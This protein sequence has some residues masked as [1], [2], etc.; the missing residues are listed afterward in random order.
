NLGFLSWPVPAIVH[1][2]LLGVEVFFF[3]SGFS[4][5]YPYARTLI[6]G[7]QLQTL[8]HFIERR[9]RKILPSYVVVVIVVALL[10]PAQIPFGESLWSHILVHL[11]FLHAFFPNAFVS[12][13][14]PL[15]SLAVEVEFYVIFPLLAWLAMRNLALALAL[16][17]AI[18]WGYR[19]WLA[20]T[21]LDG[22]FFFAYQMP[23]FLDLFAAGM[24]ASYL[25][26]A[27]QN[28]RL[29]WLAVER[30]ATT[31]ALVA[32]VLLDGLFGAMLQR[33]GGAGVW[34]WQND[35]RVALA[36]LLLCFTV[37]TAFSHPFLRIAVANRVTLWLAL[38]SYNLY[39]W[40][41]PII[42][43]IV[44]LWVYIQQ[45]AHPHAFLLIVALC[46]VL[47]VAQLTTRF[48][49]RPILEGRR[50]R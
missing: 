30:N 50:S 49:E 17:T 43:G 48:I 46:A 45:F 4:L 32:L 22:S 28:G 36:V 24:L 14:G 7:R 25:Y 1:A 40:N 11:T 27:V 13:D 39:L 34:E 42:L 3:I 15:W 12:I 18:A 23:A 26:I 38:I 8:G 2:G 35:N 19:L 20:N 33:P 31:I 44:R 29:A 21:G 41:K 37:G 47:G 6:E 5:F 10:A 16:M 9:V